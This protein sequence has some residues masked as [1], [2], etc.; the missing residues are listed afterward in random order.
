MIE[1]KLSAVEGRGAESL[2]ESFIGVVSDE[3]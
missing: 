2:W 1:V 3:K